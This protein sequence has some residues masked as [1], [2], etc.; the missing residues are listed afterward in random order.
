M[1]TPTLVMVSGCTYEKSV[2]EE[3]VKEHG[4]DPM[5]RQPVRMDQ[6]VPN[7]A[8]RDTIESWRKRHPGII[9][10]NDSDDE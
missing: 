9:S 7:R 2:I 10:D 3:Y 1:K 5:T 4:Q 6:L 8:L